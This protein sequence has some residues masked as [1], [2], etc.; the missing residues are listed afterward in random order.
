MIFKLLTDLTH[1]VI[2]V[3]KEDVA[4]ISGMDGKKF[5]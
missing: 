1:V 4:L 3:R 2:I 5:P